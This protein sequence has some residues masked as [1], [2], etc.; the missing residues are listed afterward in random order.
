MNKEILNDE[1][2]QNIQEPIARFIRFVYCSSCAILP[3]HLYIFRVILKLLVHDCDMF[4]YTK[5]IYKAFNLITNDGDEVKIERGRISPCLLQ[6]LVVS[7]YI[8]G[9]MILSIQ[10]FPN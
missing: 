2:R 5:I 7:E 1:V 10:F 9:F 8:R 4:I 3:Y 6:F